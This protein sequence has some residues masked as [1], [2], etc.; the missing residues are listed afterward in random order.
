MYRDPIRRC[1]RC[2]HDLV[3]HDARDKWRCKICQG[4]L[5]GPAELAIELGESGEALAEAAD[6]AGA[7]LDAKLGCPACDGPMRRF[8]IDD[9]E[10]DRCARHGVWFDG[11]ELGRI[12]RAIAAHAASPPLVQLYEALF[13]DRTQPAAPAE[14]IPRVAPLVIDAVEWRARRL[15]VDGGCT[16][17]IGPDDR[18][19]VCGRAAPPADASAAGRRRR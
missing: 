17:V 10:V 3:Q 19:K 12:R 11:G 14:P 13:A 6:P 18:C 15:C 2:G 1:P 5:V 4:V 16:G 8:L 9:I 7:T